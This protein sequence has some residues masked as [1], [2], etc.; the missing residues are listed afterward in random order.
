M[1]GL[2]ECV[3]EARCWIGWVWAHGFAGALDSM[4]LSVFRLCSG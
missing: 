2:S 1:N 3:G 4:G